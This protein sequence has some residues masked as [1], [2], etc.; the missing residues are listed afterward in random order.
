MY[1]KSESDKATFLRNITRK[2]GLENLTHAGHT[3]EKKSRGKQRVAY[4]RSLCKD[5]KE[6]K[7]KGKGVKNCLELQKRESCEES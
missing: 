2:G 4:L 3:E 7:L 1:F 5:M 6:Q